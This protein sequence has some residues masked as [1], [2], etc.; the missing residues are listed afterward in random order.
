L[1]GY[2]LKWQEKRRNRDQFTKKEVLIGVKMARNDVD[3][4]LG[5]STKAVCGIMEREVIVNNANVSKTKRLLKQKGFIIIGTGFAGPTSTKI[6]FNPAG[7]L[8]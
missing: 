7:M 2:K 8:L 6:W 1:W 5:R 4:I 3:R